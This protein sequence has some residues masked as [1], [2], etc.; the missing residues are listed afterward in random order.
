M[1]SAIY[2]FGG[3]RQT[4]TTSSPRNRLRTHCTGV[5]LVWVG[6]KIFPSPPFES[7]TTKPAVIHYADGAITAPF[8]HEYDL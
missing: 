4:L 8:E 3:Q 1:T 7:Q 6:P 2:V 5:W